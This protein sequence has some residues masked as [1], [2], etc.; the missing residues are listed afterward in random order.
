MIL[1]SDKLFSTKHKPDNTDIINYEQAKVWKPAFDFDEK[2]E[3][4]NIRT[5]FFRI[6]FLDKPCLCFK[7][8]TPIS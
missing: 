4:K 5:W 8:K 2:D 7:C 6:K 1:G 3:L